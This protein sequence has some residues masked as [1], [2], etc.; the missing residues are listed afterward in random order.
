[1]FGFR[2]LLRREG[3]PVLA[4]AVLAAMFLHL[5]AHAL[6][7]AGLFLAAGAI[8]HGAHTGKI[9]PL[10]GLANR[11]PQLS[12][13]AL[14]LCLAAAGLPPFG[15]FVAEWLLVQSAL[16]ALA[17]HDASVGGRQASRC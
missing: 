17:T 3:W 4:D 1:M 2:I 9:E 13:A 6:F 12:V 11:M 8:M 7:K 15:S 5:L 14:A 16:A 10:G